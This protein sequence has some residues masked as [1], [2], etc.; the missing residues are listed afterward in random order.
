[1]NRDECKRIAEGSLAIIEQGGYSMADG[2]S[3]DINQAVR[4][5]KFMPEITSLRILRGSA[6]G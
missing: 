3:F 4:A 2:Q 6:A 5:M 1:M